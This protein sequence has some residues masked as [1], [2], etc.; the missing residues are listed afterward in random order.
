MQNLD[1]DN[2]ESY[3]GLYRCLYFSFVLDFML[4]NLHFAHEAKLLNLLV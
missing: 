3:S 2:R 4:L 1:L